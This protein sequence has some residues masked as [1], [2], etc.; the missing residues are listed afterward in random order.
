GRCNCSSRHGGFSLD[1]RLARRARAAFA[2]L[3]AFGMRA[4]TR[5]AAFAATTARGAAA[6][7]ATATL[8]VLAGARL[9]Y[10]LEDL[11]DALALFRL[12]FH[13]FARL[14]RQ[15]DQHFRRDVLARDFLVDVSL[16]VGQRHAVAL[17]G[18]ADRVALGAQA[19]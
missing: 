3:A 5:A 6:T 17:A 10:F 12:R 13:A 2:T 15:R 1:A 19:R 7:A 8:G 4:G 11:A 9:A 16:D 18:K 14:A